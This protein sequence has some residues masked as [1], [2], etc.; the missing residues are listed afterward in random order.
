MREL[1]NFHRRPVFT[2]LRRLSVNTCRCVLGVCCKRVAP[3][4]YRINFRVTLRSHAAVTRGD[5]CTRAY[6]VLQNYS[7]C[8]QKLE[9]VAELITTRAR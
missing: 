4:L 3:D 5:L 6:K 1:L 9:R 2:M 8:L 7:F